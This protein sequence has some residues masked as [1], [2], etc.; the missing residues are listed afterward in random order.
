[1]SRDTWDPAQYA[2]YSDE[3]SRAFFELTGRIPVKDPARVIDLGC[4]SGELTATLAA[5][6]PAARVHGLDSSESMIAAARAFSG[7]SFSV[8]DLAAWEPDGRYD[9]IVSN[10]AFQWVPGHVELFP[11]LVGAL[12]TAGVLAFQ[13][14][15]NHF[16]PS[17]ALLR[18]LAESYGLDDRGV[19]VLSP[20]GYLA[21]LSDLGCGVDAWET[22]YSQV[23]HGP[24]PVLQWVKGTALRPVLDALEDPEDFLHEYRSRLRAAYPPGRHGTVFP[25]R[26]IFVVATVP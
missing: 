23:L 2:L 25:F 12:G 15:G 18:E 8:G 24:D 19:P 17:H 3:R 14:P 9:V 22:T 26:R 16:A 6:W 5:R 10:A 21:A 7:L 20:G 11:R 4:G 13:V 1:M